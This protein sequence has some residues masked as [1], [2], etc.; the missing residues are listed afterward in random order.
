MVGSVEILALQAQKVIDARICINICT[1]QHLAS[2]S[3]TLSLSFFLLSFYPIHRQTP[4]L[5]QILHG[6]LLLYV[7]TQLRALF[8][9]RPLIIA[10]KPTAATESFQHFNNWHSPVSSS[11]LVRRSHCPHNIASYVIDKCCPFAFL[12]PLIFSFSF[13]LCLYI[14][15]ITKK[16]T[17][18]TEYTPDI[19]R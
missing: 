18:D 3:L 7:Q 10:N 4:C 9:Q 15:R 16:N 14:A 2:P 17:K 6:S 8:P 1:Q 12:L 13:F 5:C 11:H 19:N